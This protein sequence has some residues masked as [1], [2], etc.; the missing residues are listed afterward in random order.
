MQNNFFTW[1]LRFHRDDNL[2]R[3]RPK[4]GT[5]K[6]KIEM[7]RLKSFVSFYKEIECHPWLTQN[8]H[9]RKRH[10][11]YHYWSRW[12]KRDPGRRREDRL[13]MEGAEYVMGAEYDICL[14]V[15]S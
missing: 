11:S 2:F 4:Y 12:W 8:L 15:N 5:K 13:K 10:L 3:N 9:P 14:L 7:D 1:I 6:R